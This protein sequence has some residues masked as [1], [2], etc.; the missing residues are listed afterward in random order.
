MS[1]CTTFP[2][3]A[4]KSRDRTAMFCVCRYWEQCVHISGE[5][6]GKGAAVD[7]CCPMQLGLDPVHKHYKSYE[8]V[9]GTSKQYRSVLCDSP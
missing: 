5:S 2:V 3:C 6:V 7:V 8:T 4:G 1:H 9:K